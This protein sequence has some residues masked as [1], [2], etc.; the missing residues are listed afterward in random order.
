[1]PTKI[2]TSVHQSHFV[3][4]LNLLFNGFIILFFLVETVQMAMTGACAYAS[5][6]AFFSVAHRKAACIC[7]SIHY[8]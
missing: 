6:M 3:H 8:F 1:M 2:F 5:D 7:S 4:G